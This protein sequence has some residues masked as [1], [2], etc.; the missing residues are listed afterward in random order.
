MGTL[1]LGS[2]KKA[3][4]VEDDRQSTQEYAK[5][6]RSLVKNKAL[7]FL[8]VSSSFRSMTQTT[9]LTFLPVFLA[10]EM[11]YS[12]VWVGAC[13]F[14]LQAAG[15][16]AA[17]IAGHMSDKIG[18]RSIISA[19]MAMSAIVLA[20]MAFAGKTNV[21][22]L[23]IAVLGFFLYAVRPVLQAWLLDATPKNMG[24]TSIGALFGMQAVGSSIGPI[25]GGVI[26]DQYGLMS[27]F[28]FLAG[29][30]VVANLFVFMLPKGEGSAP[31]S[32][33]K[34]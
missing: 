27:T 20:S 13:M 26:A 30:I 25:L 2:K 16:A 10:Y 22:V 28:Y 29:T 33:A 31:P 21:F 8:T 14:V 5:G 19:S 12:P 24:G 7:I 34:V 9:L 15:F 11:G 23:F 4:P 32:V 3:A 18:R 1:K 17:P 6:L